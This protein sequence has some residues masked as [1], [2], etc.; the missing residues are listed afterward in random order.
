[1]GLILV[2]GSSGLDLLF[3][4]RAERA[5]DPWSGQ[6][7]L[8]GGR[9][10]PEDVALVDTACRETLEE[11]GIALPPD[12]LLGELDDLF[13]GIKVLPRVVVRP[14]VFGLPTRP[15]IESSDEVAGHLWVS[16]RVLR[17]SASATEVEVQG[18]RLAV[19]AYVVGEHVIW[20]MTQ[21][22]VAPFLEWIG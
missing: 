21:R 1:V 18:Q 13:P 20:G 2:P 8:P 22:I 11:T 6:M 4:R 9:R 16:L 14:F 12:S 19:D 3:I 15:R 5:E 7:A 17:A 10:D